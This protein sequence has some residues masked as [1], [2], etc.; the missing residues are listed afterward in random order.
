MRVRV[1]AMMLAA[2]SVV[3][4]V[5]APTVA[6]KRRPPAIIAILIGFEEV[7]SVST[8]A[9]GEFR[10]RVD[11][12]GGVKTLTY[13]L[14]YR[15]IENATAAHLHLGQYGV[16]GGVITFLCGGGDKA[17]CPAGGGTVTGRIDSAD[18]IG[19]AGQGIAPGEIGEVIRAMKRGMVYVNV[20]TD[21][22]TPPDNSGPG[23]LATGEIRGQ[24]FSG[25]CCGE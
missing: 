8:Q 2:L 19:P 14:A 16:N 6:K 7:P 24:L 10:T 20:H 22:G 13:Q 5:G 17:D 3:A 15:N 1:L 23:D 12:S 11:T 25:P 9:K 18:V 4:L 21:D